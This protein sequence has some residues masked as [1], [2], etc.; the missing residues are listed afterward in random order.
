M[1]AFWRLVFGLVLCVIVAGCVTTSKLSDKLSDT[2]W[3]SHRVTLQG[4]KRFEFQGRVAVVASEEG[5]SGG[6]QWVQR[7]DGSHIELEGP[8]GLGSFQVNIQKSGLVEGQDQLERQLGIALPLASLRYW[9]LGVPDPQLPSEETLAVNAMHLIALNQLGWV[10]S[11]SNYRR[12]NG[13][14]LPSR[15]EVLRD[16]FKLRLFISH[17]QIP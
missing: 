2:D 3:S 17:W 5:F 13:I 12:T 14:N 10:V 4:I 1:S 15:L 7:S 8:L 6:L 11:F 16:S 9:V